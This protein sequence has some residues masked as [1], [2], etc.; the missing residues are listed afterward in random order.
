[1][2]IRSTIFAVFLLAFASIANVYA[3]QRPIDDP[4][5][6]LKISDTTLSY[7]KDDGH[8]IVTTIGMLKN[9]SD[10]RAEE[11][12]VEVKYFDQAKKL[13]DTITQPLYGIVLP[14]SQEVTF[15]VRD[16]AD[17]SKD[18]YVS[19]EVRVISA[20]HRIAH[21]SKDFKSLF[22]DFFISWGPMLLL[23]GV[24]IFFI[25]KMNRKDSPQKRSVEL[26]EQ[27]NATLARQLEVLERLA[28]AIEKASTK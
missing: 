28:I 8:N 3:E 19:S 12:V 1:M 15:R 13:I 14:P 11:L 7:S 2:K 25:R 9:L 6:V 27:Q 10:S 23:I 22:L 26:I 5:S 18:S 4:S 20:E 21:K 24:W 17:K 16:S